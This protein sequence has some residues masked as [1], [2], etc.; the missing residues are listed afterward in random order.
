MID[1]L[2]V[3]AHRHGAGAEKSRRRP[4]DRAKRRRFEPKI[5]VAVSAL[6]NPAGV[7]STA[8]QVHDPV[9]SDELLPGLEAKYVLADKACDADAR[10]IEPLRAAGKRAVIPSKKNRTETR[11]CDRELYEARSLVEIFYCNLNQFR[12]ITPRYDKTARNFLAA[13][14]LASAIIWL[15]RRQALYTD[16]CPT[17]LPRPIAAPRPLPMSS[18]AQCTSL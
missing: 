13:I 2:I 6:G 5:H 10:V 4:S 9:G 15:N 17:S 8:A 18:P 11:P 3:R 12:A 14:F 7:H 1:A 16:P